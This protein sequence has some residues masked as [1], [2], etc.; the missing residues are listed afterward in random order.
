MALVA[1]RLSHTWSGDLAANHER[2]E[3]TR[4]EQAPADQSVKRQ[5]RRLI[6]ARDQR[7]QP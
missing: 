3:D 4:S 6:I 7:R 1:R 2:N 5:F